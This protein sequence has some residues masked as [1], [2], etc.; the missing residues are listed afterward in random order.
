MLYLAQQPD[1]DALLDRDPLALLVGMLLDQADS[2]TKD[3][4]GRKIRLASDHRRTQTTSR[5]LVP[6]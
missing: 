1:A 4:L 5:E 6:G 3:S 2:L